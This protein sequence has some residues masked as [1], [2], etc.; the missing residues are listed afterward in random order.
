MNPRVEE[1]QLA[2]LKAL[3][4]ERDGSRVRE[5]LSGVREAALRGENM[6]ESCSG[7]GKGVRDGG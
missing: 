5:T 6:V 4:A 7:G 3:K 1:R 2:R